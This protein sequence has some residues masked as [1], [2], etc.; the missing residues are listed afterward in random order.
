M[1]TRI[2]LALGILAALPGI[3]YT[4]TVPRATPSM[5]LA[6]DQVALD[7]AEASS[8]RYVAVA[9][10]G[11]EIPLT[12]T[13]TGTASPFTCAAPLPIATIGTHTVRVAVLAPLDGGTWT[14]PV[15]SDPFTYR[16]IAPPSAP[17]RFR[18]SQ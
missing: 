15:L 13:C 7:L 2:L 10:T 16:V 5:K 1:T 6:W 9:S 8:Y 17:S 12:A 14:T 18:L 11:A 3:A 4:Q